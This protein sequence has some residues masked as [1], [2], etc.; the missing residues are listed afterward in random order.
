M[1]V[2]FFEFSPINKG[3]MALH[4]TS[5]TKFYLFY[6]DLELSINSNVM[7]IKRKIFQGWHVPIWQSGVGRNEL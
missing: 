1:K 3:K 2:Q 4:S 5:W 7:F 6:H